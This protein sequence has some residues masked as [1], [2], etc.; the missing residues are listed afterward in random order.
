MNAVTVLV[1]QQ[2]GRIR[3]KTV[4][5]GAMLTEHK[6]KILLTAVVDAKRGHWQ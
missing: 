6:A 2:E 4:R 1:V 3:K 5:K